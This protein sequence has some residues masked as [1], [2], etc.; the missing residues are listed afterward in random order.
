MIKAVIYDMDGVIID[1]EPLWREA[2]IFTFNNVGLDFNEDLCRIT[3][4]MRL[5]EVVEYW[6]DKTPWNGKTVEEV[7]AS[8]LKKVTELIIEKGTETAG[9]TSSLNHFKAKGYKIALASSSA[10]SLINTVLSQLNIENE[11]E[12]I[13]SAEYLSYGKPHPEIFIKTAE[14]L[15]VKPMDCLVIEDSFHGVLAAKAAVMKVIAIP[16][17][18]YHN[19]ARFSIAD[20][21]IKSLTEIK[22]LNFD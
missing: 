9:V 2:I 20:Y 4:G 16:E 17:K 18:K 1:S 12:V 13:N 22:T 3:Q 14:Q 8:L 21:N 5:I 19:D 15:K 6:Y 10:L 11:F 7:E